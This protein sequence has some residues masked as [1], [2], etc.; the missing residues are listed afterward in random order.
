M[1]MLLSSAKDLIASHYSLL[2]LEYLKGISISLKS[3]CSTL[4]KNTSKLGC[5][6]GGFHDDLGRNAGISLKLSEG[7]FR[8]CHFIRIRLQNSSKSS[9]NLGLLI[10]FV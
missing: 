1:T 10:F 2:R 7:S 6:V 5:L 8:K 4:L 3:S 9:L